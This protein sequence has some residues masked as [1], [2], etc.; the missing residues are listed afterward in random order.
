MGGGGGSGEG[1]YEGRGWKD[2]GEGRFGIKIVGHGLL[3]ENATDLCTLAFIYPSGTFPDAP[4]V[5]QHF[6]RFYD[7]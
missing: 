1:E 2:V 7:F 3:R 6:I 5:P 4:G